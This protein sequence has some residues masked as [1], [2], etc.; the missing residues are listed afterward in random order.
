MQPNDDNMN[1]LLSRVSA[2]SSGA[3]QQ[4][5]QLHRGRLR[6]M[7]GA[8]LDRRLRSR[9]DPSDVVQDV[10]LKATRRLVSYSRNPQLPFYVWLRQIAWDRLM[11]LHRQHVS[12]EKRS[13]A[14]E[15]SFALPVSDESVDVL[16]EKLQGRE[17]SPVTNT[18]RKEMQ[19]RTREALDS[20]PGADCELLVMR[21]V[22]QMKLHEIAAQ[23]SLS[24]SAT[25]SRHLRALDKLRTLLDD[26]GE[27]R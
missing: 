26:N 3:T 25:K 5:M 11:E 12:V 9:L 1:E 18:L 21:Y 8:R 16:A 15:A 19:R 17:V 24:E 13:V 27:S 22:E 7:V 23:L 2:G 6:R 4:L 14:R 20:L 10:L